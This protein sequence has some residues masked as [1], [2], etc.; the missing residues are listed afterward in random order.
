MLL[1]FSMINTV[2]DAFG[3]SRMLGRRKERHRGKERG[4][5]NIGKDG[6]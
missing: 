5:D 4:N 2:S 6:K 3:L 1:S